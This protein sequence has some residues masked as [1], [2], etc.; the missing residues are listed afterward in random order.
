MVF[1][2]GGGTIT[3]KILIALMLVFSIALLGLGTT[4]AT[5]GTENGS[6]TLTSFTVDDTAP[7]VTS[8]D[9][10][11]NAVNIVRDK[12]IKITFSENIKAG[13][14]WI[15]LKASDGTTIPVTTSIN[16]NVL[17]ITH[18]T[19][20]AKG[21]KY[22]LI[23][24][25]GSVTDYAGNPVKVIG[26]S[27]TTSTDGTSPTITS[28]N[29]TNNAVNIA[30]DNTIKVIFN[31][32]IKAGNMWIELKTSDGTL[33][34][35]YRIISGNTLTIKP[36]ALLAKGTK[37]TLILH[38]DSIR[39]LAGNPVKVIGKSFTTST[40]GTSPTITSTNPTNNAINITRD[41]VITITF[42][43]AIKA[44]NMQIEL[45]TSDGT[46]IKIYRI[47]SG[48]VLTIK[49]PTLLAKGTKHTLILYTDSIRDLKGN[50]I[51]FCSKSF[52]TGTPPTITSSDPSNYAVNVTRNK[53][54]KVTFNEKIK[55]GNMWIELKSS[56]GTT[57]PISKSISGNVLTI[58]HSLL[59]K[60][61]KYTLVLHTDSIRDLED[62]PLASCNRSFTTS[63]TIQCIWLPSN[64]QST[65]NV[66]AL[67]KA[68]ITDI[69]IK[70][71]QTNYKTVITNLLT[72]TIGTGIQIHPWITC[73][74]DT[75]G[76]VDPQNE[77]Y[78]NELISFISDVTKANYNING[79]N[80][81]INGIHLDYVRYSGSE[82]NEHAAYQHPG[83]TEAITSF[84]QNVYNTVNSIN[85][86]VAVSAALM[87]E[88]ATNA[89][90]YG[91]NYTQ[92]SDYLD[93]LVPMIY[94]G[95]YGKD[96]SWIGSTV[97]YIVSQANGKP[98]VAGL[99]T[100]ESDDATTPIPASEL[101]NDINTAI[102]N[103]SA[104]YALFRYG[105][106][107][108]SF[109]TIK[110]TTVSSSDYS[111]FMLSEIQNAA[112]SVK[113]YI[114]ANNKL[115]NY[116]TIGTSQITMPQFLQMLVTRLLQINSGINSPISA[117][118]V[119]APIN[120]T[121]SYMY[122]NI[123]STEYIK[124]AGTIKTY[125]DSNG[126]APN[127]ATSSLGNIQYESLVYTYSKILNYYTTSSKLPNNVIVDSSVTNTKIPSTLQQYLAAT[128]NCQVNDATIKS[129]AA[130]ITK[131]MSSSYD[132][133]V[134][135][136]NWVRDNI[137]Y[138][139]YYN[140]KYGAL[141][142]Y[143]ADTGNCVD[144][145]HL[146][147]ALERAVGIPARYVHVNAKFSSGSW[148]GHVY[149][150]VW[151]NGKWYYADA[152]SS[153]NTFGAINNWNTTTSTLKGIYASLPF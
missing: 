95:N 70:V 102:S 91:Q 40:D 66:S 37:H 128:T 81:H 35:I 67:V 29:P 83:G 23:L 132:K 7:V 92:L 33:I 22:T 96:A 127:Y 49:H 44:G 79:T 86:S 139:F 103:G 16:G 98:V 1:R 34:K 14:M 9:P 48:K 28:T 97:K 12:V 77:T 4:S 126:R 15:E 145:T 148:Y 108:S 90:Y 45:K 151:V 100:Y 87:P 129:L 43:E 47:I 135:I 63:T 41:K 72:R 142:T 82:A 53:L 130:S 143:K 120:S 89:K 42:N 105:L 88:C 10:T 65:V 50:P 71:N 117:E 93:F 30:R 52:T 85:P 61:T 106:I 113:S 116:I 36:S 55:A 144:T 149:A 54:I 110:S 18:S 84:V 124:I 94:K 17:T 21:K 146:L 73:F 27:F 11:N 24:H 20:L 19:L 134:A 32:K 121:G 137:G 64:Y 136:F 112:T 109:I 26:K 38:T 114:E 39:D 2:Y 46:L 58:N 68:D 141:G 101:Q 122:G 125:I 6:E 147:I 5:N 3:K 62:N 150:N 57:V 123:N 107:D 13:N 31:E 69:F 78:T 115:P 76:W 152:S 140:T 74:K 8:I 56:N 104:G 60:G 111:S 51:A 80:Y 119:S 131:G 138:S 59:E 153:R 99:Q 133:A 75:S 25:S 118:S